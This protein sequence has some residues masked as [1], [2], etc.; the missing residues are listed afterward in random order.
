MNVSN[1]SGAMFTTF[2]QWV[3]GWTVVVQMPSDTGLIRRLRS[4]ISFEP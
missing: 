1:V 3:A 4:W 2:L